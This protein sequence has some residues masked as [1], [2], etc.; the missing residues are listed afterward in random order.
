MKAVSAG[1][2]AITVTTKDGGKTASCKVTAAVS[3][4]WRTVNG[5]TYYYLSATETAKGW[6][7]ISGKWYYFHP[8]T[9]VMQTGKQTIGGAYYYLDPATGVR[10]TGEVKIKVKVTLN[11]KEEEHEIPHY[12]DPA[13]GKGLNGAWRTVGGKDYWYE[14]GM[15]RGTKYD[16]SGVWFNGTNRGCEVVAPVANGSSTKAWFWLDSVYDGAK[17]VSKEVMMPYTINGKDTTPKW[18]RYDENGAMV[19]EWYENGKYWVY[20]NK[21]SGAMLK[22]GPY[23][24]DGK[25]YSFNNSN[26]AL[27]GN[28]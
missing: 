14:K 1:T 25:E 22:G 16:P 11:G 6:K 18:V 27:I 7:Q 2:A 9:G 24:I 4:G 13:T 15:R 17:A 8:S 5:K 3:T 21:T 23:L 10:K 12:Y 20:Y 19:K 28:R 26:G